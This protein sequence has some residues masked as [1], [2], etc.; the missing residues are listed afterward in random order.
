MLPPIKIDFETRGITDK[1]WEYPPLPVGVAIQVGKKPPSYHRGTP[2][3]LRKV[4]LPYW[5][6][7]RMIFHNGV[8]F[9]IA[10]AVKHC[11]LPM[12]DPKWI[13]DTLV[14]AFLL[15]PH[16]RTLALKPLAVEVLGEANE[17]QAD[18]RAWV[19]ANVQGST[20]KNWGAFICMAPPELVAP[21]A[22]GD[23]RK[24]G[25]LWENFS[26]KIAEQGMQ[27]AYR[28]EML[29]APPLIENG[30]RG[31]RVDLDLLDR[32]EAL[33]SGLLEQTDDKI[34]RSLK[35]PA[36]EIDTDALADALERIGGPLPLTP[37]G[38]R[39]TSKHAILTHP[40]PLLLKQRL[41][42]RSALAQAYRT[43]TRPMWTQAH[44]TEGR[45]HTLWNQV[46]GTSK[47]GAGGART[48]RQSSE[49]NLQNLPSAEKLETL[50]AFL[51]DPERTK[52]PLPN[53]RRYILPDA[54]GHVIFGRDFNQQELRI[55]A[56]FEG[57]DLLEMYQQYPDIDLH[58]FVQ[59]MIEEITGRLL[60]RKIIKVLNFCTVYGGGPQ[61]VADQGDI[62]LSEAQEVQTLYFQALP[63]IKATAKEAARLGRESFV[64]TI[65][66]RVYVA[67]P[68]RIIKGRLRSFDYKLLNY[69]IQ[70]SAADQTKEAIAR[71]YE[72]RSGLA[73]F[74]MSVHDELVFSCKPRDLRA[75][76]AEL[77]A[78]M[79]SRTVL[80]FEVPFLSS[81]YTGPN[82][83]DIEEYTE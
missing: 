26:P 21:Y 34:R 27:Q 10:V 56:H 37:S 77:K 17:D 32:D 30:L 39:S 64:R 75:E 45:I 28:R 19:L 12:P 9:D 49:P 33:Y 6:K 58:K 41:L 25:G 67:E 53:I 4:L 59:G 38:E 42:Y 14:Q 23:V 54:P 60:P 15:D 70:G 71:W 18:L 24:T 2:Q 44:A 36:L 65:G 35:A 40:I 62:P 11:K 80:K 63:T 51:K 8:G 73:R 66:G 22:K 20:R 78:V 1:A 7:R 83:A 61:A 16:A 48:G 68:S 46:R 57:S 50:Y 52:Y 81:G 43:F 72:G 69:L 55:L 82:W 74:L 29:V 47:G 76:M 13:E 79:E 31:I 3:Y 5:N